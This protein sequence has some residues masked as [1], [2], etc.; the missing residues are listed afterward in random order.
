MEMM[1]SLKVPPGYVV[2]FV[3]ILY[4]P[5]PCII[6][7]SAQVRLFIH[8]ACQ[9]AHFLSASFSQTRTKYFSIILLE[10]F[11]WESDEIFS[12]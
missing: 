9:F 2:Y 6:S 12:V 3:V 7:V 4:F 1:A 5:P 8:C 10:Y 11:H